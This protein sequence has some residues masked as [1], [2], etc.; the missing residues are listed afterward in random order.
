MVLSSTRVLAIVLG[1]T[2]RL[3]RFVSF[4]FILVR[5]GSF[6]AIL[7]GVTV[8]AIGCP[9]SSRYWQR[10]SRSASGIGSGRALGRFGSLWE[11]LGRSGA[12]WVALGRSVWALCLGVLGRGGALRRSEAL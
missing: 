5:F 4:W 11:A 2:S 7:G 6:W 8:S 9:H 1:I 3:A 12:L 10:P